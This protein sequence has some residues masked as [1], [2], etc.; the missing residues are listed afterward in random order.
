M[1]KGIGIVVAMLLLM[2][3]P[4]GVSA[5][6]NYDVAP[7][8]IEGGCGGGSVEP[9]VP[10]VEE[11]SN[12]RH[13][14]RICDLD[15][16]E[17]CKFGLTYKWQKLKAYNEVYAFRTKYVNKGTDYRNPYLV[18]EVLSSN[19]SKTVELNDNGMIDG[20][21][22]YTVAKDRYG[23]PISIVFEKLELAKSIV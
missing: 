5:R 4:L 14:Q 13:K 3:V 19:G 23:K 20:K 6:Q 21:I 12:H 15:V 11:T 22:K 1:N 9:V 18:I 7:E 8:P 16:K 10:R 17:E 2:V